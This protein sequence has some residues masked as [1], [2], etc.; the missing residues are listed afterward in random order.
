MLFGNLFPTQS[1]TCLFGVNSIECEIHDVHYLWECGDNNPIMLVQAV[2][3]LGRARAGAGWK[4]RNIFSFDVAEFRFWLNIVVGFIDE[5]GRRRH[6][7]NVTKAMQIE[8]LPLVAN[9]APP[10]LTRSSSVTKS[11]IKLFASQVTATISATGTSDGC[12]IMRYWAVW[13]CGLATYALPSHGRGHRFNP[14][15]AHQFLQIFSRGFLSPSPL[16]PTLEMRTDS[17]IALKAG[18]ILGETVPVVF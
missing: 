4:R 3:R 1:A 10:K 8:P 7:G 6:A 17:E 16:S 11:R 12:P 14:C 13:G 2:C 15:A 18:G 5:K 9:F